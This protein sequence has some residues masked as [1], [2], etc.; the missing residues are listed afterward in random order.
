MVV[1][2]SDERYAMDVSSPFSELRRPQLVF[3]FVFLSKRGEG[4]EREH[5]VRGEGALLIEECSSTKLLYY[6]TYTIIC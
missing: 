5:S 1:Y 3:F 4:R 2:C 6:N